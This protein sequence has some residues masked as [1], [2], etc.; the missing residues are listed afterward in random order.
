[1]QH[2]SQSILP[3]KTFANHTKGTLE[4]MILLRFKTEDVLAVHCAANEYQQVD[5]RQQV[6]PRPFLSSNLTF[7]PHFLR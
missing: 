7:I 3:S 2:L 6:M 1:M 5:S 4:S